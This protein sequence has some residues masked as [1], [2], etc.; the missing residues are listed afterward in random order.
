MPETTLIAGS[1]TSGKLTRAELA[2]VPSPQSTATHQVVPHIEI[3]NALEEQL[4]FR[5]IAVA[6]GEYAVT[7]DGKNFF[8]VM[9]LDQG[10]EGAQFAL[11]VR[12]SHSKQFRL[13]IVVGLRIF[14]CSNLSFAGDF[15]IVLA[16]H[17]K[18]FS[19]KHAISIGIDE[20][21]RG[22][23]PMRMQVSAWKETQISDDQARLTI[24]RAFVEDQLEA[25]KHLAREVWKNWREPAY[26]EFLPR[27]AYSLQNAFTS[28]FKFLDP[29]PQFNATAK[30]AGF[31][32]GHERSPL[33]SRAGRG[34]AGSAP[35]PGGIGRGTGRF[36]RTPCHWRLGRP[37]SGRH[38]GKRAFPR[39]W[40][41]AGVC[42]HAPERYAPLDY[43]R[44]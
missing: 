34:H 37:R 36:P 1:D 27:T 2:L 7:K 5:H 8:G 42:L 13:S 32:D 6:S 22:F 23:E 26:D 17:S 28:S 35:R 14:V 43:H 3:V 38:A 21:Q 18:N 11:G 25:P 30:L 12:N 20:A 44:G 15:N 24:F 19:L 9:T 16:K 40:T 4:G 29:I 10:I 39:S 33:S 41:P 31:R